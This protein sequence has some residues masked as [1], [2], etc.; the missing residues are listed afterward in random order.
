MKYVICNFPGYIWYPPWDIFPKHW[1]VRFLYNVDDL[2]VP[3]FKNLIWVFPKPNNLSRI[4]RP[5]NIS[6][7]FA[8]SRDSIGL[9][10]WLHIAWGGTLNGSD[11]LRDDIIREN[12]PS[13]KGWYW[14]GRIV[15]RSPDH[16]HISEKLQ[17]TWLLTKKIMFIE[18]I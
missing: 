5:D 1:K 16:Q 11:I 17:I 7:Y 13:S 14:V 6:R 9:W 12:Q 10:E 3:R 8:A 15:H 18:Q 4:R 2:I